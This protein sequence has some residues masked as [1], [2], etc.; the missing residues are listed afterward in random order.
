MKKALCL[1]LLLSACAANGVPEFT[2]DEGSYQAW[3]GCRVAYEDA[4]NP[5]KAY[6]MDWQTIVLGDA[7]TNMA[8]NAKLEGPE[9]DKAVNACM[10]AKGFA[11]VK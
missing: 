9:M 7:A 11:P 10:K 3:R 1:A 5:P 8:G 2:P 6:A 4:H